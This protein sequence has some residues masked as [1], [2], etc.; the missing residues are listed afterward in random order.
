MVL[1]EL[2][3]HSR[4]AWGLALISV[5]TMCNI[6]G[7]NLEDGEEPDTSYG[8]W[9]GYCTTEMKAV[10]LQRHVKEE[11][12]KILPAELR[13]TK[14][15]P[16][17]SNMGVQRQPDLFGG[18]FS[19]RSSVSGISKQSRPPS[20]QP[21]AKVAKRVSSTYDPA[22]QPGP[23]GACNYTPPT[24]QPSADILSTPRYG[25]ETPK[26]TPPEELIRA[27]DDL[28]HT[29]SS[30]PSDADRDQ[31]IDDTCLDGDETAGEDDSMT[32]KG[33]EG[34]NDDDMGDGF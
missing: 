3:C 19:R 31:D 11:R 28:E 32:G 2:G 9:G 29:L 13:A 14:P 5:I 18:T 6:V 22:D 15:A 20:R 8:P 33:P 1:N 21:P 27:F 34:G 10:T 17:T 30:F 4:Y 12:D 25:G 24:Y 26:R 16:K 23:S 7:D